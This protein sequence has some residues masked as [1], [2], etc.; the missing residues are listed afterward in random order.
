MYY[1][2]IKDTGYILDVDMNASQGTLYSATVVMNRNNQVINFWIQ[3]NNQ[4][5][6]RTLAQINGEDYDNFMTMNY[7]RE[8]KAGLRLLI[9]PNILKAEFEKYI[10]KKNVMYDKLEE[11]MQE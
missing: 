4:V 8:Q 6:L 7:G 5:T 3:Q 10:L 9:C 2:S 11:I 1:S